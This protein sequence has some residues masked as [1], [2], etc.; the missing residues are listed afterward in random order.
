[1]RRLSR[2][3]IA[4]KGVATEKCCQTVVRR[5]GLCTGTRREVDSGRLRK[6]NMFTSLSEQVLASPHDGR[7]L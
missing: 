2:G 4:E 7:D 5:K 3:D 6:S 1:M